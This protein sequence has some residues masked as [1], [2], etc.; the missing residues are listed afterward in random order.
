MQ[1]NTKQS[2][3]V[4]KRVKKYVQN[5]FNTFSS[6]APLRQVL[7]SKLNRHEHQP[8][9]PVTPTKNG[10]FSDARHYEHFARHSSHLSSK[11]FI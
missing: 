9:P 11:N 4:T 2:L 5:A 3:F 1:K 8:I 6:V 10:D 7:F